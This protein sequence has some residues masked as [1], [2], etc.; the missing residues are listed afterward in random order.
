MVLNIITLGA[1][2]GKDFNHLYSG[3]TFIDSECAFCNALK[4]LRALDTDSYFIDKYLSFF[5]K[6]EYHLRAPGYHN[7][8][9]PNRVDII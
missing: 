8:R 2:F 6:Q 7:R 3:K 5:F 4:E 9:N 1:P